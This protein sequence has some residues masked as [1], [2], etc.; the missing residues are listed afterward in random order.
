MEFLT[1]KG[2]DFNDFKIMSRA[3]YVGAHRKEG[4]RSLI[5]K[6]SFRMNN[7]RLST[8]KGESAA[9]YLSQEELSQILSHP[10]TV[11]Y[12]LDGRVV[13]STSKK[14]LPKRTSCVYEICEQ[15]GVVI[16]AKS[17]TEA[18]SIVGLY[19]DTLSKY[20]DIE[21]LKDVY[22]EVK[23]HKVRRVRVFAPK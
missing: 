18:A 15:D 12:L 21:V 6:L 17:L 20:L 1:K 11:E 14:V 7:Y 23:E 19:P 16:L 8:Y 5:L 13:D 3:I 2:K 4:I 22:I 10:P 9:P